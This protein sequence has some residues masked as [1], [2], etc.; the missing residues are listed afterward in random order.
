MIDL[1]EMKFLTFTRERGTKSRAAD[2]ADQDDLAELWHGELLE[3][4]FDFSNE[5]MELAGKSRSR[6][7]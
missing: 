5:L 1:V 7:I 3:Q 2:P 6:P 4:L